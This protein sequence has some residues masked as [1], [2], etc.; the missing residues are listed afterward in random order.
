[1]KKSI[2]LILSLLL[3]VGLFTACG[4]APAPAAGAGDQPA[5]GNQAGTP[6]PADGE[7]AGAAAEEGP[8]IIG[9]VNDLS[10]DGSVLGTA[11]NN[12]A[13]VAIEEINRAGGINGRQIQYVAYDN[14]NDATQTI[15]A[16]TRLVDVDKA[17]AVVGPPSST[18]CMSLVEVSTEKG[19][20]VLCVPSDPNVTQNLATGEPHPSMFLCTQPN[21]IAQAE[22]CADY[23]Q[24]KLGA[25]KAAIFYDASNSYSTIMAE[26]FEGSWTQIGGSI[27]T[28]VTF[29]TGESDFKTQLQKVKDSGAEVLFVPNTTP[30]CVL[31]VQQ[32]S[33]I[34]L[35]VPFLGAM[36][37]AD[38]F[39]SLL[40]DPTIVKEAYFHA[41]AW[42]E[43]PALADYCA[44]Y[45]EIIGEPATV[46]TVQ[47]YEIV[48][49]IK[50]AIE[51]MEGKADAE[52]I[53]YGVENNIVGLDLVGVKNYTQSPTTHAPVG[54]SMVVCEIHDGVLS[55]GGIYTPTLFD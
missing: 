21:A 34:G 13:L 15:N 47:G 40:D 23:A 39:L 52:S 12:G 6:A 38:P 50:A 41:I 53:R 18:I 54:M 51:S 8:I 44:L 36:D 27:A 26:S 33:Q 7:A 46:K 16:Y 49:I 43:D 1:M 25:S 5:A 30:N 48:Y 42:M 2:A 24:T 28:K 4:G 19:V 22:F 32:A 55:N 11:V 20:P 10:G 45:E 9:G 3:A 37:M 17:V 31:I 35:E 29:Q 14:Q